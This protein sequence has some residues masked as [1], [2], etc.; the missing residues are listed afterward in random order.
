[1][2]QSTLRPSGCNLAPSQGTPLD[3]TH[4]FNLSRH[5]FTE[6]CTQHTMPSFLLG[7]HVVFAFCC[8]LDLGS[9][10]G[11]GVRF[12]GFVLQSVAP[13]LFVLPG[14]F[15][16]PSLAVFFEG[17]WLVL[18]LFFACCS[19]FWKARGRYCSGQEKEK[20]FGQI[21]HTRAGEIARARGV[22][23]VSSHSGQKKEKVFTQIVHTRAG[24][25]ARARGVLEVV[26]ALSSTA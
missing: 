26:S 15:S 10:F 19:F 23:E 21:V 18:F 22:L 20:V 4:N 2:C 6:P 12:P 13:F 1:M 25:I 14:A 16:A 24:Q 17:T 7:N 8:S 3:L 11:F 9:Q 5:G